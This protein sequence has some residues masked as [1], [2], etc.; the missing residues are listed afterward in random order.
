MDVNAEIKR[1]IDDLVSDTAC[2][3]RSGCRCWQAVEDLKAIR[4]YCD[5]EI[6]NALMRM[7]PAQAKGEE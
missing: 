2:C 7:Q 4:N 6:K 5:Q 3:D 1:R